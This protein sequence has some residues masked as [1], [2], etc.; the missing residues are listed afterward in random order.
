MSSKFAI[1]RHGITNWNLE[2]KIQ[3]RTD[4]PLSKTG[5]I[6]LS[7]LSVPSLFQ[8]VEWITSPLQRARETAKILGLNKTR[9]DIRLVEMNWGEWEGKKLKDL[10]EQHGIAMR[11]NENRGLDM[12]PPGGETPRDVQDRLKPLLQEIGKSNKTVGGVSHKGTIRALLCL[13]TGWDM[14]GKPP[15]KLDWECI[16]IFS[17]DASGLPSLYKTNLPLEKR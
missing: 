6:S 8:D 7:S 13:A 11:E 14:L 10:R 17:L 9:T 2:G 3:G 12:Q 5:R 16:Q 1:L 15:V 4:V